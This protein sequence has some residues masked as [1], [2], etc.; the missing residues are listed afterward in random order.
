[1]K[2][3]IQTDPK[4]TYALGTK[5]TYSLQVNCKHGQNTFKMCNF[6]FIYS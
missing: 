1:V 3:D 2:F 4:H 6:V 5:Y